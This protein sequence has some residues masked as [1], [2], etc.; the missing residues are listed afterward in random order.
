MPHSADMDLTFLGGATTVTGSQYLLTT[1]RARILIDCGMFQGMPN[2]SI[3]NRIPPEYEPGALDAVLLTHA[4]LD[5]CGL[6]PLL[7]KRGFGGP[8]LT[9]MG[10]IELATLVL[11]DSGRLHEEFAKREAR[12]EKRHP[13]L[14]AADDAKEARQY[15][16]ALELSHQGNTLGAPGGSGAPARTVILTAPPPGSAATGEHVPT[17]IEPQAPPYVPPP[18][19]E[20]DLR[21]QPP[22]LVV[23]LDAP[24]YTEADAAAVL[25]KFKPVEYGQ[26]LE[27][28][29]GVHATFHDAGHI[30]GSAIIRLRV[31]DRENSP[32]RVIVFSGDLGRESAPIVRDPT[33]ETSA[34][35]VLCES[36]Y[37]GREHDSQDEAVRILA[38]TVQMVADAKGVLLVPSFAIGRT[39]EVVWQLDR[40]LE[41]GRIPLL[42]LFLDS[43]MASKA[44]DVYRRHNE[45]YDDETRKLFD[46][47][48]TPLDYPNQTVTNDIK[49]SQAILGSPRPFMIVASNGMLTGGRVVGHLRM[50]IDDPLATILFVGYQGT[51]TLGSHLQQGATTVKLD[52]Q[53]REVRCKIR[54][55]SGFSSHADEPGL[56][57]WLGNFG[58]GAGPEATGAT[59]ATDPSAARK[60]QTIFLI[61]G[62]PEAQVALAPKVTALGFN[63]RIPKWHERVTLD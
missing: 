19:P 49:Q 12:W 21:V 23:D 52:G 62:D 16:A 7:V 61:H 60:P 2:E 15:E 31:Q 4:H 34:D 56:L 10:T 45:Y 58:R 48:A 42:P 13:D 54:S 6:L 38:E 14:V 37:G 44:T 5:H 63:V 51:G 9:T 46:S 8:I 1:E 17:T 30:L 50:L 40:L 36:T 39:Q 25:P 20:A 57:A 22:P 26:E 32:E 59:P 27:V 33:I 18:D 55:I 35:Y 47:G 24:L 53:V 11:L 43:P 3:R 28:A 41:E 29:P